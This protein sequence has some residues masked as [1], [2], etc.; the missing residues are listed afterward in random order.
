MN[1]RRLLPGKPIPP[2]EIPDYSIQRD[3]L[4]EVFAEPFRLRL[5][6]IAEL[7]K[8]SGEPLEGNIFYADNADRYADQPPDSELAPARRN[9]WRAVRFKERLLEVGV[10]AGHSALLALSSNPRLE[11]YGVDIM[12]HAYTAECVDF[13]K[14]EFPGRV[15]LFTGDL[16]EVLPWLVSRRA[17]LALRHFSCRRRPHRRSLPLRHGQLHSHR[18]RPARPACS[19]GRRPCELDLRCLLRI[20]VAGRFDDRDILRRLGG[21]WPQRAGQDRV[22]ELRIRLLLARAAQSICLRVPRL[23]SSSWRELA[24]LQLRS[25]PR[26]APGVRLADARTICPDES[27]TRRFIANGKPSIA[28]FADM[29]RYRMMRETGCC[30]V[31]TD[32]LCLSKPAFENDGFVFCRQ[33][34]AVG[35][36]LVNN[37]VLR[38]PPTHPA[39]AELDSDRGGRDRRRPEMGR[40]RPVPADAG[41]GQ[42]QPHPACARFAC[43]LSDRARAILEALPAR[44]S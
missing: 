13:L 34:D 32:M 6:R 9:V 3:T 14:G 16:R 30:W 26:A 2:T 10:N 29:F 21:G 37:A 22:S 31:D 36:S 44:L 39:L 7:V 12:S 41:P 24:R 27:L 15:H 20:R 17:E 8:Q 28:T 33:A 19:A 23:V 35:T 4:E 11:Y 18:Q 43:L 25:A 40:D 1:G 42:I 38:L 5:K